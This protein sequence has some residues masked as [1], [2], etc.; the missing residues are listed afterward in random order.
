MR[1]RRVIEIVDKSRCCG[2]AACANACPVDCITMELD[3]EGCEY[4]TAD[5]SRCVGCGRCERV[6]PV[7]S[8]APETIRSQRAFLVQHRD[9]DVLLQSTSGGA[10]T[11]LAQTVLAHR[12]MVFGHGYDGS[13]LDGVPRVACVA[14]CDEASL[15][16]FRNSKYVESWIGDALRQVKGFLKE[17]REV[18]FSGTP[19]QC[20]GLIN[21][22]GGHPRGLLVVDFVC[23]AVPCRSVLRAY[24]DWVEAGTGERPASVRFRDK[25]PYGYRYSSI[26]SLDDGGHLIR[27]SNV[28]SDPYLRA[29]F[30]DMCDRPSCH[31]CTFKK[32]YRRSDVT[33]WDCFDP[34]CY[35]SSFDDNRGVTRAL[36]HTDA[37]TVALE[38]CQV[39]ARILE[40]DPD[41]AVDGMEQMTT[42]TPASPFREAFMADVVSMQGAE[43][44]S[45]WFPDTVRVR[46]ERLARR[47]LER[48]GLYD[49]ARRLA[50]TVLR[51][52]RD[53][54]G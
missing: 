34:S 25:E 14:V 3:S 17:G 21:Y 32:R 28:E 31:A 49:R 41:T 35:S 4:P 37:G 2:C 54:R 42:P 26:R 50:K 53:G 29:F 8:P 15:A 52:L 38:A 1:G 18:L 47:A 36:A 5:R 16:R 22:L 46:T 43:A 24:L 13:F 30:H 9:P 19:C 11:A 27:S 33:L 44:M 39:R 10:F 23:R 51:R 48:I 45:K 40:I 6:C 12:G 7:L 20:E